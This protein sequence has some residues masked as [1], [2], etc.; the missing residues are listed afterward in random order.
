GTDFGCYVVTQRADTGRRIDQGWEQRA[1]QT[2]LVDQG[3]IPAPGTDVKQTRGGRVG[4]LADLLPGK[5]ESQQIRE[6]QHPGRVIDDTGFLIN[7]KLVDRIEWMEL[8]SIGRIERRM[9]SDLMNKID[10]SRG[11][12][13]PIVERI[14][15][16]AIAAHQA[17]V[18]SPRVD[19]DSR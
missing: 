9:I 16:Q 17:I 3:R 7:S 5:P 19:T 15:D 2:Q 12:P 11:P 4:T 10:A 8:Q 1:R 14:V 13:I 6:H 18:D